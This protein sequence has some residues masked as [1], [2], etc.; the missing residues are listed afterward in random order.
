MVNR[1]FGEFDL[2]ILNT[3]I[4]DFCPF[5]TAEIAQ[6]YRLSAI[7]AETFCKPWVKPWFQ[8]IE[9]RPV[10]LAFQGNRPLEMGRSRT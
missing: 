7:V 4:F 1:P 5:W 2:F 6:F 9:S 8:K 3:T 10:S